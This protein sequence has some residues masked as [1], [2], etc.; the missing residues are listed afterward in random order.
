[1]SIFIAGARASMKLRGPLS[2]STL[3]K[4]IAMAGIL[5]ALGTAR[6]RAR[7]TLRDSMASRRDRRR[8]S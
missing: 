8:V 3:V 4:E 1:M 2:L 5:N 7:S 6:A